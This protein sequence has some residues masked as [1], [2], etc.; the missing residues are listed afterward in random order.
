MRARRWLRRAR[1]NASAFGVGRTRL[2]CTSGCAMRKQPLFAQHQPFF[3]LPKYEVLDPILKTGIAR[4]IHGLR[5]NAKCLSRNDA[6]KPCNDFLRR[7]VG[8]LRSDGH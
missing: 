4:I 5:L 2:I 6:P 3:K 7:E 1:S 8:K